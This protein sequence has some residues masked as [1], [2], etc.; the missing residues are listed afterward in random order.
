MLNLQEISK[1]LARTNYFKTHSFLSQL[2]Q[3]EWVHINLQINDIISMWKEISENRTIYFIHA[4]GS[5]WHACSVRIRTISW[6]QLNTTL[7]PLLTAC[8]SSSSP[9]SLSDK[10]RTKS[11]LRLPNFNH[12]ESTSHCKL[13]KNTA[14]VLKRQ[15]LLWYFCKVTPVPEKLEVLF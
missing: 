7:F 2:Q 15:S 3:C 1:Y 5:T 9:C 8:V 14:A 12:W 10:D 4:A 13:L 11:P 6:A